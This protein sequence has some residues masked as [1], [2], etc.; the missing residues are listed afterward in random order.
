MRQWINLLESLRKPD[1]I[2]QFKNT[3]TSPQID[4]RVQQQ[5]ARKNPK[6]KKV[7]TNMMRQKGFELLGTGINGAVYEN[8]QYPYVLKVWRNDSGYEEWLHFCMTHQ[9]NRHVPK[10]KGKVIRLNRIFSVVRMEK[11]LPCKPSTASS[12]V[13]LRKPKGDEF[14]DT[15]E[16]MIAMPYGKMIENPDHDLVEIAK[17]MRDWEPV[18]DL[19]HHNI[20]ER[21]N[22]EI[23]IIDPLYIERGQVIDW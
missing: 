13:S 14:I 9:S 5:A 1:E 3:F 7:L 21:S 8:P 17:F 6:W 11:L 12:G 19:S 20:M 4:I 18:S 15:I 16:N 10:I 2:S 22:G 23:V